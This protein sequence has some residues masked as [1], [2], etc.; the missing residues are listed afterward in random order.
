MP[1]FSGGDTKTRSAPVWRVGVSSTISWALATG[2]CTRTV[3]GPGGPT[4]RSDVLPYFTN[5]AT[6]GGTP[7]FTY[8]QNGSG[9]VTYVAVHVE[10]PTQGRLKSGYPQRTV[11]DDGVYMR[12]LDG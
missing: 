3:I 7:V 1:E 12:N 10:V 8:T 2:K 11:Y 9:H 6:S 4:S 5:T